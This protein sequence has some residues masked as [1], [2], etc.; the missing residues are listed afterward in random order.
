MMG[1]RLL[2][3]ITVFGTSQGL[4]SALRVLKLVA[5][6]ALLGP[7][8]F[9]IWTVL[10]TIRLYATYGHL[11]VLQGMQREVPFARGAGNR[12]LASHLAAAA[13]SGTAVLT[14]VMLLSG[15]G[16]ASVLPT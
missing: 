11:G 10:R 9:G 2:R 3:Q 13:F 12:E 16:V 5:D 14:V 4:A 1:T 15:L 6:A 7:V 8:A